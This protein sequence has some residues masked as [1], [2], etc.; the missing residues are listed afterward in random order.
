MLKLLNIKKISPSQK[1]ELITLFS[2]KVDNYT[3]SVTFLTVKEQKTFIKKC[4]EIKTYASYEFNVDYEDY[5][6]LSKNPFIIYL[7]KKTSKRK[8]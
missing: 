5:N 6:I 7:T 4:K 8:Y 2:K 3:T 1:K